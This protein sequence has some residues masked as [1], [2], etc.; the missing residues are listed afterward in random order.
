MAIQVRDY[1]I[2][3]DQVKQKPYIIAVK[4]SVVPVPKILATRPVGEGWG[5]S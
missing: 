2:E 1:F 3:L 4:V 5:W